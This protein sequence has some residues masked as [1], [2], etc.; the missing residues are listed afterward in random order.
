MARVESGF[1]TGISRTRLR[2]G[3]KVILHEVHTA[4]VTSLWVWYRVGSRNERAGCTGIS[5][6]VE[7]MQFRGTKAFPADEAERAISRV[8]GV[9]NA[10]TSLDWTAYYETVPS[11][12]IDLAL[13]LESDRMVNVHYS[14]RDVEAERT[15]II[16]ERQGSENQPLF[17]LSEEV[18]AAA[19]R[20]HPYHHEVIGDQI[21]IENITL[22]DLQKHYQTYYSPKNAIVVVVGDFSSRPMLKRIREL[23]G[24]HTNGPQ[25]PDV[26]RTEPLQR[27]ER[28]IHLEG[29]GHTSYLQVAFHAPSALAPDFFSL[30]VL[31]SVLAGPSAL[32]LFGGGIGN[33]TSRLYQALVLP[34]L[35][36]SVSGSLAATIDPFL[37]TITCTVRDGRTADEVEEALESE[38][39]RVMEEPL[40]ADEL[41]KAVKQ[42]KALFSYSSESVSN[43]GFWYGFSEN[44][45]DSEWFGNY[46][47][48][49]SAVTTSE[50]QS[51]ANKVFAKSNRTVGHYIPENDAVG[52]DVLSS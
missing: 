18:Q 24:V 7:H 45:V 21:D 40:T 27:G 28:R 52:Y 13:R 1:Q 19:F 22:D 38:L 4:P 32:N 39:Q 42:A 5:H 51:I 44:L 29:E 11:D 30:L 43:L 23:F 14:N 6:W 9:W 46:I 16:S 35:A 47:P 10:M 34:E 50:V 15:V 48:R 37:Y 31:D 17:L 12:Q 25:G 3:L 36:A 26:V 2:N 8:G 33:K 41:N 20:V 49:L